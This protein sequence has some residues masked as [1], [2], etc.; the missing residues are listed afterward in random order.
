MKISTRFGKDLYQLEG[1]RHVGRLLRIFAR[2]FD[3]PSARLGTN[4]QRG[5]EL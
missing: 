3:L 2:G 5:G 1:H 4:Q